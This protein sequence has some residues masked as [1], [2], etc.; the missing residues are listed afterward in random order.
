MLIGV[1]RV[2]W[3]VLASAAMWVLYGVVMP[4][5]VMFVVLM[6]CRFIP[7]AGRTRKSEK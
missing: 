6:I 3:G 5:A 4:I 2:L 1:G 7:L